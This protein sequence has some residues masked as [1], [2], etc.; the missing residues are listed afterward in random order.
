MHAIFAGAV[1]PTRLF[2]AF[3]K[4]SNS[5]ETADLSEK[6]VLLTISAD[7]ATHKVKR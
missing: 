6:A 1:N 2:I 4:N 5:W 7:P 3:Q